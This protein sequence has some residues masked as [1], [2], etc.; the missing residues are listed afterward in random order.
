[1]SDSGM[2]LIGSAPSKALNILFSS[3]LVSAENALNL[4]GI[5]AESVAGS[6]C[7]IVAIGY[8]R[9]LMSVRMS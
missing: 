6:L 7:V 9:G 5:H 3:S 1:M 8:N 4:N 2:G